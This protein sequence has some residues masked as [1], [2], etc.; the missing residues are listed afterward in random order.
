MSEGAESVVPNES[1]PNEQSNENAN[2]SHIF[3]NESSKNRP[4]VVMQ[5]EFLILNPLWSPS[6]GYCRGC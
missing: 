2:I 4:L 6:V 5:V 3:L 1:E